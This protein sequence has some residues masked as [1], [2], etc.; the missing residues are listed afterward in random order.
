ML[1]AEGGGGEDAILPPGNWNGH[2]KASVL[3]IEYFDTFTIDGIYKSY[4]HDAPVVCED[5]NTTK[6]RPRGGVYLW[7]NAA[8]KFGKGFDTDYFKQRIKRHNFFLV[9]FFMPA[10]LWAFFYHMK[11]LTLVIWVR[12]FRIKCGILM[13]FEVYLFKRG[14][15]EMKKIFFYC[16]RR[17]RDGGVSILFRFIKCSNL[18]LL[19]D[20]YIRLVNLYY[21]FSNG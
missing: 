8:L 21:L 7:N 16:I 6:K 3:V 9:F 5:K 15:E 19:F 20:A 17:I 10:G 18:I 12:F 2:W 11:S 14:V 1:R 13:K 4:T